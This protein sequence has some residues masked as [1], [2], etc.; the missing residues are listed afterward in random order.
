[1]QQRRQ[2]Q[3][4][5]ASGKA[6][7]QTL[8]QELTHGPAAA[9]AERRPDS[10]LAAPS[11]RA[12]KLQAGHVR[13]RGEQQQPDGGKQ[14]DKRAPDVGGHRRLHW[15]R[16]HAKR[17][18][19]A[20]D[21]GRRHRRVGRIT[22]AGGAF[23]GN[24]RRGRIRPHGGNR[25][26]HRERIADD[27]RHAERKPGADGPIGKCRRIRED[28]DHGMRL[29]VELHSP[30]QHA[31]IGAEA[32]AP[33]LLRQHHDRASRSGLVGLG[34]E[35][36]DEGRDAQCLEQAC[37]GGDDTNALGVGGSGE[38]RG[39]LGPGRE[40]V[41]G[42]RTVPPRMEGGI[43][44]CSEPWGVAAAR[45]VEQDEPA[46]IRPRQRL[47]QDAVGHGEEQRRGADCER[48]G[49]RDRQRMAAFTPQQPE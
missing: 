9:G 7:H 48:H 36:P 45:L 33:H 37:R 38:R 43:A 47:H 27:W 25:V 44:E 8:D 28:A 24:L 41:D 14:H 20:E 34:E 26:E 6:E 31:G 32:L 49:G 35:R 40:S 39:T 17:S 22:A 15:R 23:L 18:V 10:H 2:E 46:G 42:A 1:V 16:G 5:R 29:A 19:A 13:G 21:G 11:R 12:R 3:S 30:A 4:R